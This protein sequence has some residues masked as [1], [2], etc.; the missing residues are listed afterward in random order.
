LSQ[1][2]PWGAVLVGV[3]DAAG[4]VVT[5]V[6]L[7]LLRQG[8]ESFEAAIALSQDLALLRE[9][10]DFGIKVFLMQAVRVSKALGI[11]MLCLLSGSKCLCLS[12]FLADHA[13]GWS[14]TGYCA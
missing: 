6:G 2:V 13:E 5:V 12:R 10:T 9:V 8:A 7:F 4:V 14:V 3:G 1:L 11:R